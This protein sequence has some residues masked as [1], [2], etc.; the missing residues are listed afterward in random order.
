MM[1]MV[2]TL[3][4]VMLPRIKNLKSE[5]PTVNCTTCHRGSRKPATNL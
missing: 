1:A 2:D 5:H 3:N 4:T